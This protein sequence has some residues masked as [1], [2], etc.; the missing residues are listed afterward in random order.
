M[1]Q[2]L[3]S[4][5]QYE[6]TT[7]LLIPTKALE[8]VPEHRHDYVE[9][10]I[11]QKGSATHHLCNND[12][13]SSQ[14]TLIPGDCFCILPNEFHSYTECKN[15]YFS[16]IIISRFLLEQEQKQL[17]QFPAWDKFFHHRIARDCKVRLAPL[18]RS[19]VD[20]C[21]KQLNRELALRRTGYPICARLAMLNI[22]VAI[23]RQDSN[24][25]VP[26][27]NGLAAQNILLVIHE[28]ENA[29]ELHFPLE[30]MAKKAHMSVAGFTRLFRM[31]TGFSPAV[32]LLALRLQKACGLL[33]G[34]QES[35]ASIAEQSGFCDANY[36]I[37]AFRRKYG[38]TP[39]AFRRKGNIH[40]L[41]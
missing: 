30:K 7:P 24:E 41:P 35:L 4:N 5:W 8:Y 15:A 13:V 27:I 18:E 38:V 39:G 26:G 21:L 6:Q 32:Y 10:V 34:T 36:L 16:N 31:T 1:Y 14:A 9:L 25:S 22:L 40:T 11:F 17:E 12:G 28:I 33:R 20:D 19:H 37:K 2:E 3:F 23:L 29:P